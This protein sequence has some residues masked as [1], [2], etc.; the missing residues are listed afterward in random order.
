MKAER[1]EEQEVHETK[2]FTF[3]PKP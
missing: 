2:E 3:S 1:K